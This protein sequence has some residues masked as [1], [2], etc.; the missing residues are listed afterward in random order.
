MINIKQ[1]PSFKD[2][3]NTLHTSKLAALIA[4]QKIAVRG[5]IQSGYNGMPIKNG[6]LTVGDAVAIALEKSD[7]L[8]KIV[9]QFNKAI[10]RERAKGLSAVE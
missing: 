8:D 7:S 3:T 4:E 10:N 2:S 1:V 6:T 9:R 5:V